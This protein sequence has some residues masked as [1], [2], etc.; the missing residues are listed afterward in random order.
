MKTI[1]PLILF[2][3]FSTFALSQVGINTSNPDNSAILDI[4]S[5]EKGVLFPRLTTA[6]RDA[7][8]NP[9]NGLIIFN[10]DVDQFQYNINTTGTPVWEAVSATATSTASLGQSTK[11]SNIDVTT[12]INNNAAI[13]LPVF[14]LM[15]WNDNTTL[16]TVD[17]INHTITI[18]ETGRYEL[19]VNASIVSANTTARKAPEMYISVNGAQVGSFSSTGYMRRANGH[20]E[21]TLNLNEVIHVNAGD[22]ISIDILRAGKTGAVNLRSVGSTNFY[23]EKIL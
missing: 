22:V 8:I 23:I 17:N 16:Y 18:N 1:I 5:N 9:A 20:E 7:I 11:Y 13:N 15:E 19:L 14:G 10:T 6:E 3:F 21:T 4:E 12:N 2:S